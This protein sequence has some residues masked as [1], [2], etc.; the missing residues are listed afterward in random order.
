MCWELVVEGALGGAGVDR[1][2]PN[3]RAGTVAGSCPLRPEPRAER[4]D[5][6]AE[7]IRQLDQG[8]P[9]RMA[10][11]ASTTASSDTMSMVAESARMRGRR[12]P[13]G[14]VVGPPEHDACRV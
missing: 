2:T 3:S 9:Q 10:A 13:R 6:R 14:R 5:A 11:F 12:D 1:G 4:T 7:L 8:L